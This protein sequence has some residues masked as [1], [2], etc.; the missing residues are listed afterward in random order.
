MRQPLAYA[1]TQYIENISLQTILATADDSEVG[2]FVE[3]DINLP[4]KMKQRIKYFTFCP[5][6]KKVDVS[7][8]AVC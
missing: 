4:D 5:D 3:V 7:P 1:E 8:S 2:F 6:Y